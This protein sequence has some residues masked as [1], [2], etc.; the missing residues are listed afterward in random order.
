M[1]FDLSSMG[2][3]ARS[4]TPTSIALW[5]HWGK[6]IQLVAVSILKLSNCYVIC[7]FPR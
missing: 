6:Q 3:T 5:A 1:A 7:A 4:H 2:G